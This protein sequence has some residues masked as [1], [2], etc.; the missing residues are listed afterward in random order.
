MAVISVH[1]DE[2]ETDDIYNLEDE[3]IEPIHIIY[4]KGLHTEQPTAK[5]MKSKL[6]EKIQVVLIFVSGAFIKRRTRIISSLL[7]KEETN[8]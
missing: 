4:Q 5:A 8:P 6:L 7:N 3:S 2:M 1:A